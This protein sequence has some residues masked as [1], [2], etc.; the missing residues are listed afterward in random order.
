MRKDLGSRGT[1]PG[2]NVVMLPIGTLIQTLAT[3]E[4]SMMTGTI[5]GQVLHHKVHPETLLMQVRCSV[6][7][8]VRILILMSLKSPIPASSRQNRWK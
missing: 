8:T 3:G 4:M 2:V 5:T 7:P 1:L 6:R